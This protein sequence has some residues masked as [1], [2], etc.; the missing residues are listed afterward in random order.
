MVV[1]QIL[2]QSVISN[3]IVM[4]DQCRRHSKQIEGAQT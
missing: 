3:Q 4:Y 1:N 2:L